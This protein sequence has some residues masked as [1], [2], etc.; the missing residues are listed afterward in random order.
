M[1]SIYNPQIQETITGGNTSF[2]SLITGSIS[3]ST[4][5]SLRVSLRFASNYDATSQQ[6]DTESNPSC[7]TVIVSSVYSNSSYMVC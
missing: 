7:A 4:P 2:G 6:E 3:L 5:V 1:I